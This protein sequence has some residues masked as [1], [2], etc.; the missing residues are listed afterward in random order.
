MRNGD[1]SVLFSTQDKETLQIL[2]ELQENGNNIDV[3]FPNIPALA[4]KKMK[5]YFSW[6]CL[7]FKYLGPLWKGEKF[8]FCSY[9]EKG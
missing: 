6:Y 8:G 7:Q 4:N 5:G 3:K 1:E 9:T 2:K